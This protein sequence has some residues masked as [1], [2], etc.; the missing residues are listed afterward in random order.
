[1]KWNRVLTLI[2]VV[3]LGALAAQAQS[4]VVLK[5]TIPFNF[6]V[7]DKALSSGEYTINSL[8]PDVQTLVDVNGSGKMLFMTSPIVT[9]DAVDPKLVFYCR[10]GDCNLAQIWTPYAGHQLRLSSAQKR[11]AKLGDLKIVA[12]VVTRAH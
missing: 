9:N 5:A 12:A 8:S 11:I 4:G 3:A 1:M 6:S 7:G 2:V 10:G